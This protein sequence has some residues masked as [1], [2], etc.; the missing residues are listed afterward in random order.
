MRSSKRPRSGRSFVAILLVS[1]ALLGMPPTA[2]LS[3]PAPKPAVTVMVAENRP[4]VPGLTFTGRAVAVEKVD[5]RARVSGYLE[6]QRFKDGQDVKTGDL[7]F[8]IEPDL[9]QA[10]VDQKKANLV[11]AQAKAENA[12][13][14]LAR[15]RELLPRQTVSQAVFEDRQA[16]KRIADA[17][18]LQAQASLKQAEIN[19][20]YTQMK[21]PITGRAGQA[22]FRK[23]ALVGPESGA[24]ATVVS[25]DPIYV[26]FP[27]SQRQILEVRERLNRT[28][29]EI[30]KRAVVRLQLSDNA[31]YPSPGKIDFAD[32][33][34]DRSTDTL[35][36]RAIF[37]N[38]NGLLVDGQFV[39][40]RV[41]DFR[42]RDGYHGSAARHPERSGGVLRVCRGA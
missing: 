25:R 33:T 3:Q 8:V 35:I 19:L 5:I 16:E 1:G 41:E 39:R 42:A 7:M 27:V 17:E 21:A 28:T 20:G 14:Q 11:A 34:V 2:V 18:V 38:Q 23:G 24:L 15:A 26:T 4:I 40:V 32:V 9:F 29:E 37:P 22:A 36:I 13:V 31:L 30:G 10:E 6:E 12:G